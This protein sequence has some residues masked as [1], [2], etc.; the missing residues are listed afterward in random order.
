M[1]TNSE[2]LL[3]EFL[4]KIVGKRFK[5]IQQDFTL[6]LNFFLL[7]EKGQPRMLTEYPLNLFS[8]NSFQQVEI[9]GGDSA[10]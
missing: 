10:L 2:I 6:C 4:R 1:K 5:R 7:F 3:S 9:R 8:N